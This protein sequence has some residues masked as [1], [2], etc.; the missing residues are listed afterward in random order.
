MVRSIITKSFSLVLIVIDYQ[1]RIVSNKIRICAKSVD[2]LLSVLL[3][4]IVLN[5]KS[6]L[7]HS[8][9]YLTSY[10]KDVVKTTALLGHFWKF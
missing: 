7:S 4:D 3:I 8:L 5:H 1:G 2:A 9:L 6:S 10:L